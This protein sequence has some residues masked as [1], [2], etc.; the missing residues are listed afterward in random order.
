MPRI[1]APAE[2]PE[3]DH[4]AGQGIVQRT[5]PFERSS[6]R[7]NLSSQPNTRSMVKISPHR[8]LDRKRLATTLP[9]VRPRRF[10]G[11]LGSCRD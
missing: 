7:L 1:L 2:M 8:E 11:I 9:V 6:K 5:G 4:R 10:S 3:I